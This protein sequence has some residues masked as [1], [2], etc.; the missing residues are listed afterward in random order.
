[1]AWDGPGVKQNLFKPFARSIKSSYDL[2][3]SNLFNLKVIFTYG[4]ISPDAL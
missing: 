4:P 2:C 1:M 3:A